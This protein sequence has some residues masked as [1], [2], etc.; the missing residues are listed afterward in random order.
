MNT[1]VLAN[2]VFVLAT[3][4]ALTAP[5]WWEAR[6]WIAECLTA[7]CLPD[8]RGLLSGVDPPGPICVRL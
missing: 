5:V 7:Q 2:L 3:V 6:D 8:Q 4:T 1:S